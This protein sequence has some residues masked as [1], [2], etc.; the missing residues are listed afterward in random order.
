[1]DAE[2]APKRAPWA[3]WILPA[4]AAVA[5]LVLL[6]EIFA[7]SRWPLVHDAAVFQYIQFLMANGFAPYRDIPDL[8]MP[9]ALILENLAMHAFGG[10]ARGWFLWDE[11]GVAAVVL[12]SAWI[13]GRGRRSAGVIAGSVASGFHFSDGAWFVGQR[14]WV[15]AAL[16]LLCFGCLFRI[17]RGGRAAWWSGVTFLGV[18]ATLVKPSGLFFCMIAAGAGAWIYRRSLRR[19]GA[20]FAWMIAGA[21]VPMAAVVIFLAQWHVFDDFVNTWRLLVP[22][23]STLMR[24][25]VPALLWPLLGR[26]GQLFVVVA[27]CGLVL[28]ALN[29][30]WRSIGSVILLLGALCGVLSYVLQDKG[31]AYH[32]YP[33]IAFASLWIALEIEKGLHARGI[34]AWIAWSLLASMAVA[35]PPA[36]LARQR[37]TR[38][39]TGTMQHLEFDLKRA[40]GSNLSHRVQCLDETHTDCFSVLYRLNLVESTGFIHDF[41]LFPERT[42]PVTDSLQ[43]RFL[44]QVRARPPELIVLSEQDWPGGE[45]GYKQL[46]RWPA[47]ASFLAQNYR[48]ETQFNAGPSDLAGYRIYVLQSQGGV[49]Q[50]SPD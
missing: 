40:G 48:L 29:R 25:S 50:G 2:T 27:A 28:F 7:A 11:V 23:Y 35:L 30:S 46:A 26:M 32:R 21:A 13:A 19:L 17:L 31:W 39:P 42:A 10:G 14:D 6:M 24:I 33:A 38:Y 5:V 20:M 18:A 49:A 43:S 8:S 9:G 12:G 15:A 36:A 45:S 37:S 22:Y 1:M 34:R 41:Y 47:F 4:C 3:G 44:A 16:L